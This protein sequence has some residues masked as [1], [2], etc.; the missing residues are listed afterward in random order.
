M[1]AAVTSQ[2][3][4]CRAASTSRESLCTIYNYV[5]LYVHLCYV[6]VRVDMYFHFHIWWDVH[7]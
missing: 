6:D 3:N 7:Y 1:F 2:C 5:D 4:H